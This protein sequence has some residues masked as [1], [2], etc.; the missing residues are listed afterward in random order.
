MDP[1]RLEVLEEC[2]QQLL[3]TLTRMKAE[4]THLTQQL[5]HL[6][7][8]LHEQQQIVASWE[9]VQQELRDQRTVIYTLQ[10]EREIIRTK[11]EVILGTVERLEEISSHVG[12]S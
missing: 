7:H 3:T 4:R 5:A 11:L 8:V 10:Q 2:V 12:E 6:Q 9:A 1:M